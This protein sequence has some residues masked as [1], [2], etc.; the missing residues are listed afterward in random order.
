MWLH[1]E[2]FKRDNNLIIVFFNVNET[3]NN[4]EAFILGSHLF[5]WPVLST[6][7]FIF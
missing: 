4:E 5:Y 6:F 1:A 2:K 7:L 3:S